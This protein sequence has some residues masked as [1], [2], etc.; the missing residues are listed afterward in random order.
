MSIGHIGL[1]GQD[2]TSTKVHLRFNEQIDCT[3]YEWLACSFEPPRCLFRLD[4]YSNLAPCSS[5]YCHLLEAGL[6][7]SE[8]RHAK[9]LTVLVP[10][11]AI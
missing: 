6:F 5:Y 7:E 11:Q 9:K 4:R 1:Q 3:L 10:P 2:A 8:H